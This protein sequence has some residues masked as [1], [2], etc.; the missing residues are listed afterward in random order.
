MLRRHPRIKFW[1]R[2]MRFT[3]FG[4]GKAQAHRSARA[5][6]GWSTWRSRP[7]ISCGH[8]RVRIHI[9]VKIPLDWQLGGD[10]CTGCKVT[11][12]NGTSK[13]SVQDQR[14]SGI[15]G[16]LP[17]IQGICMSHCQEDFQIGATELT[18]FSIGHLCQFDAQVFVCGPLFGCR[19]GFWCHG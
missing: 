14:P 3:L 7:L 11:R 17:Q 12:T 16:S 6:L 13:A 5:A 9:G 2:L 1:A 19:R 4:I 8:N 18:K 10:D 15:V